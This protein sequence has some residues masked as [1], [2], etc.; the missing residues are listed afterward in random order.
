MNDND[1]VTA[2][3]TE[4]GVKKLNKYKREQYQKI[5]QQYRNYKIDLEKVTYP[6]TFSDQLYVFMNIFYGG[7]NGG[8]H[9]FEE[10][11]LGDERK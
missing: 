6:H 9:F 10:F 11:Y 4:A 5:R 3:L 7:Y 8:D 2:V 1:Y